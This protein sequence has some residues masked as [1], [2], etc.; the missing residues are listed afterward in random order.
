MKHRSHLACWVNASKTGFALLIASQSL[1]NASA[2]EDEFFR[3]DARING[4][5]V[6]FLIDTGCSFPALLFRTGV[7]RLGLKL[8]PQEF[9]EFNGHRAPFQLTEQCLLELP[10]WGFWSMFHFPVKLRVGTPLLLLGEPELTL[11][12][13]DPIIDGVIGWPALRNGIVRMD[14]SHGKL[15]FLRAVPNEAR[16]W[17]RL[18]MHH[19]ASDEGGFAWQWRFPLGKRVI[20]SPGLLQLDLADANGSRQ[21]LMIDTGDQEWGIKLSPQKWREWKAAHLTQATVLS[22]CFM[23]DGAVMVHEAGWADE[24]SFGALKLTNVSVAE[25]TLATNHIAILSFDALKHLDVII[26]GPHG[27][28]YLRPVSRPAQQ[29]AL[30]GPTALFAPRDLRNKELVAHVLP[31]SAAFASGIRD[32]DILLKVDGRAVSQWE[33][34]PGDKWRANSPNGHM[35]VAATNSSTMS[36]IALTLR[37]GG[38]LYDAQV[39][40]KGVGIV[41]LKLGNGSN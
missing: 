40:P 20:A 22:G 26:D 4:Q 23:A 12:R 14:A 34:D 29:T 36:S 15:E 33:I 35:F 1:P 11:P 10:N 41:S 17:F 5:P 18:K 7:Q 13:F 19:S 21:T 38:D 27:V 6:H 8:K 28:A 31:N 16:H 9:G 32:G 24:I 25:N 30:E 3:C 37:R 2:I 39:V